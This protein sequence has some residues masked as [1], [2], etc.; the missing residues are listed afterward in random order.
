M[1]LSLR[2]LSFRYK[3]QKE[4]A[5]KD[6][7]LELPRGSALLIAGPSGCGKSTLLRALVGLIPRYYPGEFFGTVLVDGFPVERM[8]R[9]DIAKTFGFVFQNPDSQIL[10]YRVRRDIGLTL[11]NLG[12]ETAEIER[13]VN[14]IAMEL[15]IQDILDRPVHE[16]SDGQRQLV[17][18][19][20]AMI[21]RPKVLML[22]EPTSLLDPYS[23]GRLLS[24]VK[25]IRDAYK[26][27]VIIVEHRLELVLKY[28][29]H[30]A[31]MKEGRLISF[32]DVKE[33]LKQMPTEALPHATRIGLELFGGSVFLS[34]EELVKRAR[35][36]S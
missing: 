27:T 16:L 24:S 4:Y 23:A 2:N 17:A 12:V 33:A 31:Y 21:T 8:S 26:T 14:E 1:S 30:L 19:A 32:G 9:E 36:E 10:S 25:S 6:I 15:G 20:G 28:V 35:G 11:E 29:D 18:L 13:R 7:N 3:G 22:D 34:V 5:I